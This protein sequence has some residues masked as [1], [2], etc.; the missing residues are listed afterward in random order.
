MWQTLSLKTHRNRGNLEHRIVLQKLLK[1][2]NMEQK[3]RRNHF[4]AINRG[5]RKPFVVN[6]A[7]KSVLQKL[8]KPWNTMGQSRPGVRCFPLL[9]VTFGMFSAVLAQEQPKAVLID[10]FGDECSESV[11]SRR[12]NFLYQVGH[13][14]NSSGFILFYGDRDSEGRNVKLAQY[15]ASFDSLARKHASSTIKLVRGKNVGNLLVQFW[16]VPSGADEPQP[17]QLFVENQ[18]SKTTRFDRSWADFNNWSGKLD[19]YSDGFYDLGCD[20]R[21]NRELFAKAIRENKDLNGYLIVYTGFGKGADRGKRIATFAVNDL[22]RNYGVRR[23]RLTAIY[24]GGREEPEIEF[25]LVPK[26]DLLPRPKPGNPK[27][28]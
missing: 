20:F 11:M 23:A 8:L 13:N 10:E 1:P 14:P 25:W 27:K 5:S 7:I 4:E 9:L 6:K 15:L 28:P 24:G 26:G 12:D 17:D 22:V 16:L 2:W 3:L 21:P 18:Y 19:I